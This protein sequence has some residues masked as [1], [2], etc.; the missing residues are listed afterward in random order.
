[1]SVNHCSSFHF[2]PFP[3]CINID[4]THTHT[5]PEAVKRNIK[6]KKNEISCKIYYCMFQYK[7]QTFFK[8][9][10]LSNIREVRML[11][12]IVKSMQEKLD[13]IEISL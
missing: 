11:C 5:I 12:I 13:G 9:Q 6:I 3:L 7:Q 4:V 10:D 2:L 1:M 8:Q